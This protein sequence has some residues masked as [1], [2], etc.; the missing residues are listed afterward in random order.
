MK[1]MAIAAASWGANRLDVFARGTAT[2]M[3]HIAWTGDSW[4]PGASSWESLG[5]EFAS[6]PAV[7]SWGPGRLDVF[8]VGTNGQMLHKAWD[9]TA[10][11]PAT[12]WEP[13]SIEYSGLAQFSGPP[14]VASW[15]PGRLDIFAVQLTGQMYHKAWDGSAWAP[16]G[17]GWEPM[18]GEF[19]SPPTVVSWGPNRLD[20]FGVGTDGQLLYK[21][22]DGT[23]WHPSP[24]GWEPL[25]GKFISPPAVAS[26]GPGRL[27]IFG[28][29]TDRQMYHK[30]W[31]GTAWYPSPTNWE[32]LGGEFISP[33][34]VASWGPGRL[35]V[36]GLGADGQ[37]LHKTWT[38]TA[39]YP[40]PT[41]WEPL[42]GEFT[43]P[44]A[45]ASWGPGWL[46]VF[47][48][49]YTGIFGEGPSA[50]VLHK[51]WDGT[52]WQPSPT[53]WE[54]LGG[55]FALPFD[56]AVGPHQLLIL[57][58]DDFMA[59]AQQ[60]SAHKNQTGLT[61]I[62]ASISS[63]SPFFPGADDPEMIKRAIQYAYENFLT[64]YVLLLGDASCFPVRYRFTHELSIQY[65]DHAA[66]DKAHPANPNP[67]VITDAAGNYAGGGN[68]EAA[69]LYY[70]NLYHHDTSVYPT[71]TTLGAFDTWDAD[72]NGLYNESN[73]GIAQTNPDNVDGFP[74]VAVG[75][76]TAHTAADA[77]A[78]VN[79]VIAYESA[80]PG[81]AQLTFV[82][83]QQYPGA[84]SDVS[85]IVSGSGLSSIPMARFRYL[86][87]ENPKGNPCAAVSW[88]PNRLDIFGVGAADDQ[89]YHKTW[90]GTAWYPSPTDWE[91]LGG[92]LGSF[93][94]VAAWGPDRLDIFGLGTDGQMCHKT[95]TGTAWYPSP[96]DW[97]PLG[98]KF[99]SP[100]AVASWGP[101]R[102]DI[103][104]LG[105]D[106]QMYHKTWTGTAWYPSPTGW[107]PLGGAFAGPPA[108]ASWGPGWLDIFGVGTDGQMLHKAWDG[109]A[110]LPS[111][112]GWDQLGGTFADPPT[113][114]AWGAVPITRRRSPP[115]AR[116]GWTSSAWE[117]TGRYTTRPW[118]APPGTPHPPTGSHLAETSPARRR[119]PPGARTGWTSSAWAPTA[120]C[121][122]RPG[123]A[124]PG[125]PHPPTGNRSARPRFSPA[126]RR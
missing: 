31:T 115:G 97:E 116:T 66:W 16:A 37:M 19:A 103:F 52:A 67:Q 12:N 96:T 51:A 98:G 46:D 10:W 41:N 33:P 92:A 9:G 36:F 3:L 120:R 82:A 20:I 11:Q 15:G 44:P 47:G 99:T 21:N 85:A 112:T 110:W 23:A 78:Y 69:D 35:D 124:P 5:G 14:A 42:G 25:G 76:V 79:K 100:P 81:P 22:W 101:G 107:E 118:T 6:P 71:T 68:F 39:W 77:A 24:T 32:P 108:V 29:G 27:D 18:G 48:V 43:S 17:L 13:L 30:T 87:I 65:A 104:G 72:G 91:P 50:Q 56:G 61:T 49:G 38:G 109:T 106:S 74:D 121:C 93:V 60:L 70:A 122:T 26:W 126:R 113:L 40:S 123:P 34:A 55:Q 4:S 45:V 62:A 102:L 64:L 83:D 84:T 95:W 28:L 8:A 86:E 54:P 88:G 75:R 57:A 59:A 1:T 2:D 58:P 89:M 80:P 114:A 125:I 119:S 117:P 63:L 111:P 73:W 105:T 7:A 90:T 94:A 53:G